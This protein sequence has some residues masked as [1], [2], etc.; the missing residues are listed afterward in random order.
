MSTRLVKAHI[1]FFQIRHFIACL[2][3]CQ[4]FD[5][6]LLPK[7]CCTSYIVIWCNQYEETKE[8]IYEY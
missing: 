3:F 2:I 4:I 7:S 1:K 6:T 5:K 8:M